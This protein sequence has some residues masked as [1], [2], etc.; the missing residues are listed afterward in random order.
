MRNWHMP[1]WCKVQ[2]TK[3]TFS[4]KLINQK[5]NGFGYSLLCLARL[6]NM[7]WI[8]ILHAL[9]GFPLY[10]GLLYVC[11]VYYIILPM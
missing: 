6:E 4:R 11:A 3:Q 10:R 2:T 1:P 8:G 9:E 7:N 5:L